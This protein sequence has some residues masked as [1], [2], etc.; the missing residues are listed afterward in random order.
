MRSNEDLSIDDQLYER[1]R[2]LLL[3]RC[4]LSFPAQR[5]DTLTQ[6]LSQIAQA[7]NYANLEAL[8]TDLLVAGAPIWDAVVAQLT[9]GETYFFRHAAQFAAL[10]DLIL[11][12]LLSRRQATRSLRLWSAGCA[13]GEEPYSLA[14]ILSEQ[15]PSDPPWYVS[16]L[17]TDLNPAFLERARAGLYSQW[18]FR[19]TPEALRERF[20]IPEGQRWRLRPEPR[21]NVIFTRLNL[22]E[23][24]YPSL[25]NGTSSI[26]LIFCRN[27]L[28]YFDEATI[29]QVVE[30]LFAALTPGGWLVVGHSE[31]NNTIFQHFAVYNLPGTVIY[32][33]PLEI[34]LFSTPNTQWSPANPTP[35]PPPPIPFPAPSSPKPPPLAIPKPPP[36]KP[37]PPKPVPVPPPL[38]VAPAP[39]PLTL[40]WAAASRGDWTVARTY[41]EAAIATDPLNAEAH[42]LSGQIYEHAG[43]LEASLQAYRRSVYLNPHSVMGTLGMANIWRQTGQLVE[44]K[45]G[46][47]GALRLLSHL[48]PDSVVPNAEGA[49]AAEIRSFIQSQ[50][51]MLT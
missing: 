30:R 20:F 22:A 14:M 21:R 32:R 18:S 47:L 43:A 23:P 35:F 4:G 8:Y 40:A 34:P 36:P 2:V 39:A 51:A 26:D 12:D 25:T 38:P 44:A 1:Y 27:V 15:L 46:Y 24:S 45:R 3:A 41:V 42:Y 11:P 6:S 17:A 29:R 28:I 9:I 50:L 16:I 19:E 31:P 49:S 33:K 7:H 48:T 10:R 13:T 37:P 5:R